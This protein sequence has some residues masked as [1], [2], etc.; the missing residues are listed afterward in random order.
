MSF[1]PHQVLPTAIQ[2][3]PD[4]GSSCKW[5]TLW[6]ANTE[7][8]RLIMYYPTPSVATRQ[9]FELQLIYTPSCKYWALPPDTILPLQ[10]QPNSGSSCNWYT[11]WVANTK[12][13]RLI[14]YY[15]FSCNRTT[16]RVAID[17]HFELQ[18][19]S[20]RISPRE[21]WQKLQ[22]VHDTSC[23]W[24]AYRV[25]TSVLVELQSKCF[26]ELQ[27]RCLSSCNWSVVELQFVW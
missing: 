26:E 24:S 7:C 25:A 19:L 5:C 22:L 16:I 10:L 21:W 15:P 13:F 6:V 23:N 14:L 20:F 18:I 1:N 12:C 3:Q 2:L 11:L 9:W 4:S 8:F 17:V 27:L